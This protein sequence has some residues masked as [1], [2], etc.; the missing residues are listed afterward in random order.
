MEMP[1]GVPEEELEAWLEREIAG[2]RFQD[3]RHG[4]RFRTL[5]GQLAERIGGSISFAC[6]DWAST[7]ASTRTRRST[8]RSTRSTGLTS[9]RAS[10]LRVPAWPWSGSREIH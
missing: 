10:R 3:A 5:L 8:T 6:Q 2:C 1:Q 9:A 7:K 4:K